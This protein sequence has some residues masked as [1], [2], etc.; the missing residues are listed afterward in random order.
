MVLEAFSDEVELQL[1]ERQYSSDFSVV[2]NGRD[3]Y[4]EWMDHIRLLASHTLQILANVSPIR[5]LL[6]FTTLV[7]L[8]I[9]KFEE[10]ILNIGILLHCDANLAEQI[11]I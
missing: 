6:L 10:K 4:W 8:S 9:S 11:Q 7:S 2:M 3:K 1:I 5:C